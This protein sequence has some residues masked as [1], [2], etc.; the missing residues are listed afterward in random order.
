MSATFDANSTTGTSA[1]SGSGFQNY[2]A[3]W[4]TGD[5]GSGQVQSENA[6]GSNASATLIAR[7]TVQDRVNIMWP[8]VQ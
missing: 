2:F 8:T 3:V 1:N 6:S 7:P 5:N 4:S